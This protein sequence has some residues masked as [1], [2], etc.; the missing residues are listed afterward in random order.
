MKQCEYCAKEIS[1]YD[2]YC[3]TECEEKAKRYYDL[4]RNKRK[5]FSF[6]NFTG[7]LALIA[8][9]FWMLFQAQVG[10]YIAGAA[11]LVVGILFFFF[12]FGTPEML[13]KFK[14]EKMI[15]IVKALGITAAVIGVVL[16]VLGLFV[17]AA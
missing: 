12:P 9:L 13:Q 17:F 6:F 2:Q 11:L 8:G 16:I 4:A 5:L 10:A 14:I 15:K 3:S 1:Y 7:L